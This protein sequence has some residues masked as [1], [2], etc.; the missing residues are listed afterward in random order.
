MEES[1]WRL[2][3]DR[4]AEV[5]E[6]I[7]VSDAKSRHASES[8]I[9]PEDEEFCLGYILKYST[10]GGSNIFQLFDTAEKK[11]HFVA[12]RRRW[13]ERPRNNG[14]SPPCP[15]RTLK[16]PLPQ[17]S[18]PS[19]RDEESQWVAVE[20]RRSQRVAFEETAR[21]TLRYLEDSEDL[22]VSVKDL[23]EQLG[24]SEAGISIKQVAQQAMNEHSQ[25]FSKK[26][27]SKEKNMY[28]LPAWPDGTPC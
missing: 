24:V 17:Q 28:A 12:S 14:E 21:G 1:E 3:P 16:T 26:K 2:E 9:E 6:I 4:E 15:E 11:D 10:R 20:D 27:K 13:L 7:I 18:S 25:L 23:Q 8:L 5:P 19:S 22:K